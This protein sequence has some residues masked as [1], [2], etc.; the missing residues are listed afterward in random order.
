MQKGEEMKAQRLAQ[1]H[2]NTNTG[3]IAQ[4]AV[5][6]C[7]NPFAI[8]RMVLQVPFPA[9]GNIAFKDAEGGTLCHARLLEGV[10]IGETIQANAAD[11][12]CK[13]RVL[14]GP[15]STLTSRK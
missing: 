7:T 3:V 11:L 1:S 4:L 9:Y 10:L 13:A 8:Y 14:K 6:G 5:P 12:L 2:N 15:Y